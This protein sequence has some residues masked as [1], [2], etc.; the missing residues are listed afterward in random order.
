ME[1]IKDF[2]VNNV[3]DIKDFPV[4]N[5][6]NIKDFPVNNVQN[7]KDFPVNNVQDIKEFSSC[8]PVTTIDNNDF[9][10]RE[11]TFWSN[12]ALKGTI[13]NWTCCSMNSSVSL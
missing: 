8:Q 12:K 10:Q 2:P 6:E 5:V 4:N 9:F 7:I 11:K 3:Q 1:N 13:I